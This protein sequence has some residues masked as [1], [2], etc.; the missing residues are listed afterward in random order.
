MAFYITAHSDSTKDATDKVVIKNKLTM[1]LTT[2]QT[3][4]T[5]QLAHVTFYKSVQILL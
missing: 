5:N 3:N 2:Q 4:F 1:T